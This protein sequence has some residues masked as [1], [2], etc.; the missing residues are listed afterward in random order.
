MASF[1]EAIPPGE[2]GYLTATLK[3]STLRGKVGRGIT[4]HSN[5]PVQPRLSLTIR[6]VILGSV[7][8][9][10]HERILVSNHP[11]R[12]SRNQ[13]VVRQ[14][15]TEVGE[16]VISDLQTSAPWLEATA[17]RVEENIPAEGGLPGRRPGDWVIRVE[18]TGVGIEYGR[19]QERLSF[20]TGLKRQPRV[21]LPISVDIR[22]PVLL[23]TNRVELKP[24]Q[25]GGSSSATL[26]V[27]VP[28]GFPASELRA[29]A[30]PEGLSVELEPSGERHFKAR[31]S[32]TGEELDKGSLIF[33]L[34]TDRYT[35]PV[36]HAAAE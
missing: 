24:A 2:V 20:G 10:P 1:D 14:D 19:R 23:S 8:M 34:G 21:E 28:R 11:A 17:S 26:L 5:D 36:L 9:L 4:V 6:A 7:V 31:L 27:S 29:S 18:R 25:D 13:V 15:P 16:L 32:W 22:P 3:T 12:R 33:T 30:E 35:V